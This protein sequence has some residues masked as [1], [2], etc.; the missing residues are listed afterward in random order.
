VDILGQPAPDGAV[1]FI[2][3]SDLQTQKGDPFG[4]S[5]GGGDVYIITKAAGQVI[6]CKIG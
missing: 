2:S 6:S 5:N 4:R 1:S 3:L